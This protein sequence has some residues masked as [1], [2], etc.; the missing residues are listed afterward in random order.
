MP[1]PHRLIGRLTVV[2]VTGSAL[3]TPGVNNQ[4]AWNATSA[5]R[6]ILRSERI[7]A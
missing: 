7:G 2:F 1:V 5:P 4:T 6:P 3:A